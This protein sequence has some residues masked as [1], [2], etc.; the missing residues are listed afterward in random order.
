MEQVV[1]FQ[2]KLDSAPDLAPQVIEVL[3]GEF[4]ATGGAKNSREYIEKFRG[5]HMGSPRHAFSVVAAKR[6]MGEDRAKCDKE[7][8][9]LLEMKGITADEALSMLESLQSW[10]SSEA[11]AFKKAAQ[12]KWPEFTR[13]A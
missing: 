7:A 13:L 4:K 3:K 6:R 10:R 1:A 12:G 2:A 11:Q 9:N 5:R 8:F